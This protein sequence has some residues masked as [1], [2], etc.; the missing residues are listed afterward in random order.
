VTPCFFPLGPDGGGAGSASGLL[1]AGPGR[2]GISPASFLDDVET[3]PF[4][5]PGPCDA[6][7]AGWTGL[8]SSLRRRCHLQSQSKSSHVLALL[9]GGHRLQVGVFPCALPSIFHTFHLPP[10]I[11]TH[12]FLPSF[13][14]DTTPAYLP[15]VVLTSVLDPQFRLPYRPARLVSGLCPPP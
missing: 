1:G 8:A 3:S 5:R 12:P 6:L 10:A 14:S 9:P 2:L 7:E 15:T 11:E 13:P 4:P